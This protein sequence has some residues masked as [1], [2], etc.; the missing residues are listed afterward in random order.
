[1]AH[2][3]INLSTRWVVQGQAEPSRAESSR[4]EPGQVKLGRARAC[5][6]R[7]KPSQALT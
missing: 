3:L 4:A 5:P 2:Q 6:V 7:V 1:M